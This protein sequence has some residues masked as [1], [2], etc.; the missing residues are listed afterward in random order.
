[1]R[2]PARSFDAGVIIFHAHSAKCHFPAALTA[3]QPPS[4][5]ATVTADPPPLPTCAVAGQIDDAADS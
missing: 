3:G 1:M 4:C 2:P 5:S